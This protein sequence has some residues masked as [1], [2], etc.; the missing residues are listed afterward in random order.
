MLAWFHTQRTEDII[1]TSQ[2]SRFPVNGSRPTRIVNLGE[3]KHTTLT[4]VHVV[5]QTVGLIRGDGDDAGR[6]L[7]NGLAQLRL[8]LLVGHSLMAQIHLT[9]R[10]NLL[11]GILY[12]V[13]L[14]HEPRITVGIGVLDGHRL[15]TLQG[16]DEIA[17][18]QHVQHRTDTV[19]L[20]L[21]H[22]TCGLRH[23]TKQGL[24]LRRDIVFDH[25]LI[26]AQ[27]GSMIATDTLVIIGR[28][29][30]VKRIR[31]EVQYAVV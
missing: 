28:F 29:V 1:D 6:I 31:G 30:L 13:E 25:L 4:R 11:I 23:S 17:R 18:I 20:H 3:Y 2:L 24:H 8:E 22:I 7:Y 14:I 5:G 26:A 21:R 27:L 15:T 16:E 9:Y 19:A 12:I 10:I